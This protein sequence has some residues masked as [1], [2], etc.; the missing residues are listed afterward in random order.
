MNPEPKS[1]S[2]TSAEATPSAARAPVPVWLILLV[3][4]LIYGGMLSF[5]LSGGWFDQQV[6]APYRSKEELLAA[7]PVF[8]HDSPAAGAIIYAKTCNACHQPNGNGLPGQFP[9]L[10]KSEWLAEPEPGR[11]I[12]IVLNGL[13]GELTMNGQVYNGSMVPWKD[14]LS[15]QDIAD[16]LTFVRQNKEW[17]NNAPPVTPERVAQVRAKVGP[18]PFTPDELL[19]ISPAD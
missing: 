15:D 9:P 18:L 1:T 19:K 14:T 16:V 4:L 13:N 10:V 3:F 8:G 6:Y 17:G 2:Q 7:Q 12:R 5:D 11:I